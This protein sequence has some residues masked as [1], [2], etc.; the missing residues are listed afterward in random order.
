MSFR[1]KQ[2]KENKLLESDGNSDGQ[3]GWLLPLWAKPATE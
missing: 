1:I 3:E 2:I